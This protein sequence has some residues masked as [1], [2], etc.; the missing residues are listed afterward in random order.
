MFASSVP[1]AMAGIDVKS[2]I[3]QRVE[4]DH[5]RHALHDTAHPRS[6]SIS[7][8]RY[9]STSSSTFFS[10][11]SIFYKFQTSF[12]TIHQIN[13]QNGRT[14]LLPH[15]CHR[16]QPQSQRNGLLL[17][18]RRRPIPRRTRHLRRD[19]KRW[20]CSLGRRGHAR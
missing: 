2:G 18:R 8:F 16:W 4:Y 10:Q 15:Q 11:Q 12:P 7:R 17:Q 1:S 3:L 20:E 9:E 14:S 6:I 13:N 5:G 19:P